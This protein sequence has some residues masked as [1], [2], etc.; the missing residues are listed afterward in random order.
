[1]AVHDLLF[2]GSYTPRG[3]G[4]DMAQFRALLR[5]EREARVGGR[6][7]LAER[8][9]VAKSTIQNAEI[10]PDIPGIDTVAR[11]IEAMPGLT[12]SS[13]FAR[14]EDVERWEPELDAR[15]A[16]PSLQRP[17]DTLDRR[18]LRADLLHDIGRAI[19]ASAA[20]AI[21]QSTV[22]EPRRT[23]ALP[24]GSLDKRGGPTFAAEVGAP[25]HGQS[26]PVSPPIT[27]GRRI[28][29]DIVGAVGALERGPTVDPP[30]RPPRAP[31]Q[32][33]AATRPRAASRRVRDRKNR[34]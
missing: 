15:E 32:S 3:V 10:G 9:G 24:V 21:R 4:F 25:P 31:G 13:F 29:A 5:S 20:D 7:K 28:R 33:A 34:R 1:M 12:L 27:R 23:T 17:A 26:D 8:V 6:D 14:V 19:M 11:L 30:A 2:W 16:G 18:A 22:G